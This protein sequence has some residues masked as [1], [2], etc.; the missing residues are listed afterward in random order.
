MLQTPVRFEGVRF[1]G[2]KKHVGNA[3]ALRRKIHVANATLPDPGMCTF[4][5][6]DR[7]KKAKQSAFKTFIKRLNI[8][9]FN[10]QQAL[11]PNYIAILMIVT[12][13]WVGLPV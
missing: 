11:P 4:F 9:E 8:D 13:R 5:E 6:V 10:Q 3:H 1:G 2:R 12:H 7:I